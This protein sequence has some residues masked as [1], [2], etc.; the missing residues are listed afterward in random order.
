MKKLSW[1]LLFFIYTLSAYAQDYAFQPGEKITYAVAYSVAGLYVNAGTASFTTTKADYGSGEIYHLVGEGATNTKY[2]WIFKVR[3]RYESY[4]NAGAMQ[5]VKF[6]RNVNEGKY[7]KYEEVTFDAQTNT[8]VTPKGAYK[9]PDNIQDVI[10]SVY[11]ARNINFSKYKAG[12]KIPFN[13]FFGSDVY[14]MYIRYM[15]KEKIKTRYGT[16]N[17]IKLQP[18]LLKGKTFKGGEDMAVWVTD[19]NNHVPVRIESKLSVGSI[20]VDLKDYQNLKYPLAL[21]QNNQSADN[22]FFK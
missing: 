4:F 7:K 14:S 22:I 1:L 6:I 12:D 9:V 8:A 11:Y 5:P 17:T 21:V 20:K 15:G 19:D 10:S 2:D 3:D 13:M 16:F 18:L